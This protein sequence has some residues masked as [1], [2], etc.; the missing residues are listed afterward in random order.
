[1]LSVGI[2]LHILF[3]CLQALKLTGNPQVYLFCALQNALACFACRLS[4]AVRL[5][6]KTLVPFLI[7]CMSQ[8][9]I[10]YLL[11]LFECIGPHNPK[12]RSSISRCGL[13]EVGVTLLEE[14]CLCGQG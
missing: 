11:L 6:V 8:E 4:I 3:L 12:G 9:Q 7:P 13:T 1:M 5:C 10:P 2:D 14:V